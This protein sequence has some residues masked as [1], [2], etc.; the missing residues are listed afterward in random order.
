MQEPDTWAIGLRLL[1]DAS[2]GLSAIR[3]A[4]SRSRAFALIPVEI[5]SLAVGEELALMLRTWGFTV[6]SLI[7]AD[8]LD[9]DEVVQTMFRAAD[10]EVDATIVVGDISPGLDDALASLNVDFRSLS[11]VQDRPLLWCGARSFLCRIAERAPD[12]WA[13]AIAGSPIQ[14]RPPSTF[15][16]E[17]GVELD[18]GELLL[19][20]LQEL[21]E[22]ARR[23]GDFAEVATLARCAVYE[24]LVRGRAV[25][26]LAEAQAV[27][28]WLD[29]RACNYPEVQGQLETS[30]ALITEFAR[31]LLGGRPGVAEAMLAFPEPKRIPR[32]EPTAEA[33]ACIP[34]APLEPAESSSPA[35][36]ARTTTDSPTS[37]CASCG[38]T[39]RCLT[40][41]GTGRWYEGSPD[42]GDCS[43]CGGSGL[44]PDC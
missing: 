25:Q 29:D 6:K 34:R 2:Q 32:R 14:L 10:S 36:A 28:T 8:E 37:D 30:R 40:C 15:A 44:C 3:D 31:A 9:W 35:V 12:L 23:R 18:C 1:T 19:G 41:A 4:I 24:H 11:R 38:G 7:V 16:A 17:L 43:S 20:F 13:A 21:V 5:Q 27:V 33:L 26:G 42:E 39:R 22:E